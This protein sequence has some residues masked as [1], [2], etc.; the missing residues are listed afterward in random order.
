MDAQPRLHTDDEHVEADELLLAVA[1][2]DGALQELA[3]GDDAA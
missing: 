1:I 3:E 2:L